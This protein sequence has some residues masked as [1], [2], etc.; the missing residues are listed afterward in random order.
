MRG[1]ALDDL[2]DMVLYDGG[3]ALLD[4]EAALGDEDTGLQ[5]LVALAASLFVLLVAGD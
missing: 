3:L 2:A 4:I 5:F 1:L